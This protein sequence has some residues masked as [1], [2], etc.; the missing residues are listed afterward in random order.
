MYLVVVNDE[1]GALVC[2][3]ELRT[4]LSIG[5]TTDNQIILQDSSVSRKHAVLYVDREMV[6]IQD[7]GSVNGVQ[8]DEIPVQGSVQITEQSQVK[9]GT[10]KLFIEYVSPAESDRGGFQTAVVHPNQAHGK[11][12]VI[13][14]PQ[15][16]KEFYLFE[17]ITS[18]GRTEEND[19]TI[20]H[21]SVSRHHARLKLEDN[22]S[23]VITDPS[24][25]NG[26]FV[27]NNRVVQGMRAWHGDHIRFGQIECLLVDPMGQG[28]SQ[29][30]LLNRKELWLALV[31]LALLAGYFIDV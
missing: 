2:E 9:I 31:L 18:V 23:Y 26:T 25:S 11:I 1:R 24:S 13:E 29:T 27:R 21:I 19:I 10:F 12:V 28:V 22:G 14:G 6:F 16:G 30:P 8:V 3:K 7:L 17:P 5:R 15:A 20:A 4:E